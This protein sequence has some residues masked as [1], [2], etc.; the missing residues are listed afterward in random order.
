MSCACQ[1]PVTCQGFAYKQIGIPNARSFP[2]I[3]VKPCFSCHSPK[4]HPASCL[5]VPKHSCVALLQFA[6][7]V[8]FSR[9]T[10]G[11]THTPVRSPFLASMVPECLPHKLPFHGRPHGRLRTLRMQCADCCLSQTIGICVE[12]FHLTQAGRFC[13]DGEAQAQHWLRLRLST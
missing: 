2:N 1:D 13:Q 10:H 12:A 3:C 9:Q 7:S 11:R 5:A 6:N 4:G 8:L